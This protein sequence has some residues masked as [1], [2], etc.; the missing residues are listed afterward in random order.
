MK[1]EKILP[2]EIHEIFRLER[3]IKKML[4]VGGMD[5]STNASISSSKVIF[6]SLT[7]KGKFTMKLATF[8]ENFTPN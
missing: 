6:I 8:C 4:G 1:P 7:F 5:I 3:D 2:Q